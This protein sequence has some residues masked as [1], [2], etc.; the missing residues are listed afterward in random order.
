MPTGLQRTGAKTGR[1]PKD[2]RVVREPGVENDMWW[3]QVGRVPGACLPP[4]RPSASCMLLHTRRSLGSVLVKGLAG[5]GGTIS[6]LQSL[7][8]AQTRFCELLTSHSAGG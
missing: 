3:N 1:S 7:G 8:R 5:R 6:S 2:K 4:C